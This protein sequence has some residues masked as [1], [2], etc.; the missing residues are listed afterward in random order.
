MPADA[1]RPGRNGVARSFELVDYKVRESE[2]FLDALIEGGNYPYFRGVQFCASAFAAAARSITFAIQASL[3]GVDAFE[4]W[5]SEPRGELECNSLATFFNHFRRVTQ[6]IGESV[7][8]AGSHADG[9]TLYFFVPCRDLPTVPEQDVV[10]ACSDYFRVL[11]DVVYRCYVDFGPVIDGQQYFTAENF[12]RLGLTIED[13]EE[14]LG[15]SRGFTDIGDPS[16]L[17]YRWESLRREADGCSIQE[18][19]VRW[20]G[21]AVPWPERLPPYGRKA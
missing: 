1:R 5:Y 9:R 11:L 14:Q 12:E 18:Q 17:P 19:F 8:D 20:L 13:A 16:A 2:Y 15:F 4:A 7:V 10:S 3:R 6:H 21:K